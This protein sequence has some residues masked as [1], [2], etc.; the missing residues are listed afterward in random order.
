VKIVKSCGQNIGSFKKYPF[1]AENW[2]KS[3]KMV[4]QKNV[5]FWLKI[6]EKRKKCDHNIGSQEKC[7][8][9]LKIGENRNKL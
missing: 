8:F 2:R 3:Q 6:G 1:L 9:L 7:P 4:L 5:N